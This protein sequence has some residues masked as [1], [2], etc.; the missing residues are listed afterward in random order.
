[1]V[2]CNP[3]TVSTDYD[4]SDKLYFEPLTVEDVMSIYNK[5]KP[6]GII[7][8]FG[9]QTPLNIAAELERR[10]AHILGTSPK[11]IDMAEDRDQFG[12]M[13]KKLGIPMP[14]SGMAVTVDEAL[15]IAHRI[16]YPMM[17]RPSYVL[18]GRGMEVVYDDA[19]LR[20]YMAAAINVTPER[21]ILMDMF[22][23]DAM[24]CETDAISDGT[25]AFVPTVMQH[26]EQA[27]IHS[28]DSACVIPS[29]KISEKIKKSSAST[30][31][32]LPARWVSWA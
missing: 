1:M 3:E 21:P 8:Q 19:M 20:D 24:E 32:I 27:G 4:T 12:A 13:M 15:E 11:V 22:L 14:E 29:V 5:E 17:V 2:N 30:P 16:G 26:I 23:Q 28:G 18:G 6:L 25:H 7:V 31:R 9:G 10:G